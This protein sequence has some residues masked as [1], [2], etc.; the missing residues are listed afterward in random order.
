LTVGESRG[1]QVLAL[2]ERV[3]Q[4]LPAVEIVSRASVDGRSRCD[5]GLETRVVQKLRDGHVDRL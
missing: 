1:P 4:Q 2:D 3:E 5:D